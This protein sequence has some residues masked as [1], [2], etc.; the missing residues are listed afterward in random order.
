MIWALDGQVAARAAAVAR[1]SD[2]GRGRRGAARSATRRASRSPRPRAAAACAARASRC[3]AASCS[4]SP[5]SSG[6]VD[7]DTESMVA[8]R[9]AGHVRHVARGHAA[10]RAR[11][12]ARPLA[13]VDRPVDRRRLARVPRRRPALAPAT[14]RSRTWSSAS[15]SCS[16]TAARSTPAARRAPRSGPTSPSSSSARR[17]RSASS[18]APACG[19]TRAP[20]AESRAAY[21]FATFAEGSTR[22]GASCTAARRPR[23]SAST[24]RSRPTAASRPATAHVLLVLDEGDPLIVDATMARRRRGVRGGRAARR[25]RSSSSGWGTATTCRALEALIRRGLR[26]RHDGDRGAVARAARRST[27]RATAAI[28]A[29]PGHAGGVARTRATRYPDGAC[30]YFT[31]AGQPPATPTATRSTAAAWD[32]GHPRGARARRR[33]EPPPRRRPQPV[34]LRRA[35]RSAPR[36][37]CSPSVKHALDPNGILNPGKLGLPDPWGDPA[38]P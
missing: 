31:F 13:P 32:A 19:C 33:A 15:T 6:I 22:A 8:R 7:V 5:R 30:L 20:P 36:S 9:A 3:T 28:R 11:R 24:T 12:D 10:R 2:A 1:P 14:G 37:T 17:G 34:A 4:T 16:P 18:P 26:R 25:R 38:W 21:A 35:T 29:V 23:C 27:K